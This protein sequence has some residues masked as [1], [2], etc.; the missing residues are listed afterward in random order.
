M[1]WVIMFKAILF[2]KA[3]L[4]KPY[5]QLC[6][7][8][9]LFAMLALFNSTGW[10]AKDPSDSSQ[11]ID[12][13]RLDVPT[14]GTGAGAGVSMP[15]IHTNTVGGPMIFGG[16]S[17][18]QPAARQR[19]TSPEQS[20]SVVKDERHEFQEFIRVSS[21]KT[22][23]IFGHELFSGAPST[24][25]P[26]DNIP[27]TPDYVIGPGDE[28]LVRAWGQIDINFKSVVDRNGSIYLPKVG[29]IQLAGIKYQDLNGYLKTAIGRVFKS[30]ELTSSMGQLRSVQ[31]FV[32]GYAKRPGSYTVSSL[33]SLVSAVFASGGPSVKGSMRNIQLKRDGK[34]VGELDVYDLLLKGDK[35]RDVKLLP[36]DIIYI[37]PVGALA[38][39]AGSVN[40]E[41]IYELK[42]KSSLSD[43]LAW[44]GG[45]SSLA[46]GQ[47]VTVER[48]EKHQA[49]VVDE[50]SLDKAGM[51]RQLADGDLVRVYQL[52]PRFENTVTL[53]GN[54]AEAMRFPW[55]DGMRVKD[56]IPDR[57]ALVTADYWKTRNAAIGQV[58]IDDKKLKNDVHRTG[59]EVNW[60]YAV[61]ERLNLQT[62]STMLIPFNLGK[63]IA[64][65]G[66]ANNL[67]LQPSDVIT[68]FSKDD[69]QVPLAKRTKYVRLE[70]EIAVPG[71][72]Q[73]EPG[74][75][76][77][78]LLER[79]GGLTP[80]AYLFGAN[81]T[82]ESTRVQQQQKV[83]EMIN[84]MERD[85][86]RD[87]SNRA[88]TALS[89]E[90]AATIKAELESRR[91][92][93]DKMRHLKPTGRIVLEVPED[94]F[95]L[96]VL[97]PITLEDEDRLIIPP[98]PSFVSVF[99]AV[100]NESAF[101]Y[102]T[103]KS[104]NDYLT[105]A[106]GP[107]RDADSDST[108]VLRADG[109][110]LSKR[111][112]GL[113]GIFSSKRIMPGDAVIVPEQFDKTSWTKELKDWTQILYQFGLGAAA[114]QTLK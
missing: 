29:E 78:K 7:Q 8:V 9:L 50:F 77:P 92:L 17:L 53:R 75:S 57:E 14:S 109:S 94:A 2:C 30:F 82:R 36:G 35:S 74:E 59:A 55:R 45:L 28:I 32:V 62:L 69:L 80:N 100:Y 56:V 38:A 27:V 93:I 87:A 73:I 12:S 108:Y 112:A 68:I 52:S 114:I 33:S 5:P 83:E 76:L 95:S 4:S 99:G 34:V 39:I 90:D 102:K 3:G 63:A 85:M 48:I 61:I 21:G 40:T 11:V 44:S 15:S 88:R 104:I 81:F 110:V 111:Q 49:R 31:I 51:S 46:K 101:I 1:I 96:A 18:N 58:R 103:D 64:Q 6:K 113:F 13:F 107:T 70:G 67:Q 41:A 26:V 42:G 10:A 106:G 84:R 105:Q 72:Y 71:V 20:R 16:D 54:V 24:F 22:L 91:V 23:P 43:L 79:V 19:D 98:R 97:P 65:G 25:A 47:K 37:P 66:P 89:P 86:E 60:D